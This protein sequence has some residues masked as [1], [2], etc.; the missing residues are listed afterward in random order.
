MT[1]NKYTTTPESN[2]PPSRNNQERRTEGTITKRAWA[3]PNTRFHQESDTAA[4]E[5]HQHQSRAKQPKKRCCHRRWTEE[6]EVMVRWP[7]RRTTLSRLRSTPGG[8][9][10][11]HLRAGRRASSARLAVD[12]RVS[13]ERITDTD[14]G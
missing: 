6:E 12:G 11:R 10:E 1:G 8:N 13:S 2:K 9:Q 7:I 14:F 4:A 5:H 3:S